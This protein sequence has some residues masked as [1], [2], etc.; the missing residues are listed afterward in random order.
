[1]YTIFRFG[2]DELDFEYENNAPYVTLLYRT[3]Y[4]IVRSIKLKKTYLNR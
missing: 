2:V 3:K 1:M 4:R